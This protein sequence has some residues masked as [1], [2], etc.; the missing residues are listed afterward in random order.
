M[1]IVTEIEC[2][3]LSNFILKLYQTYRQF[4]QK[5]Q[6][7]SFNNKVTFVDSFIKKSIK[8]KKSSNKIKSTKLKKIKSTKW[9]KNKWCQNCNGLKISHIKSMLKINKLSKNMPLSNLN[10]KFNKKTRK[11]FSN[12]SSWRKNRMPFSKLK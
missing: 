5:H 4:N 2:R 11:S 1:T 9:N 10:S 6:R 3:T 8:S 7:F 12:N